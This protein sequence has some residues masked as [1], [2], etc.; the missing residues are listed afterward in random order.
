MRNITP[1]GGPQ[2]P[3]VPETLRYENDA[4]LI[5]VTDSADLRLGLDFNARGVVLT[6][7][8]DPF[9]VADAN[10]IEGLIAHCGY[11]GLTF[12]LNAAN[13]V[14]EDAIPGLPGGV[15]PQALAD[16][17]ADRA[18][19]VKAVAA[20]NR[21]VS[22]DDFNC[23]V[24]L[25]GRLVPYTFHR[26]DNINRGALYIETL[27]GRGTKVATELSE[28]FEHMARFSHH[29]L[30]AGQGV[31]LNL[32]GFGLHSSPFTRPRQGRLAMAMVLSEKSAVTASA[33]GV[34]L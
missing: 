16:H 4:G 13:D 33:P 26:D 25:L 15:L 30:R 11:I 1:T 28:R 32:Q 31:L 9:V 23:R 7:T 8:P 12:H 24:S 29:S 5:G 14:K 2:L 21:G 19:R 27:I 17:I 20:E 34:M 3:V 22:P 18:A 6:A 10:P